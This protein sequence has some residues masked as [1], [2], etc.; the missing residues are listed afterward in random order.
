MNIKYFEERLSSH[1]GAKNYWLNK[2]LESVEYKE[3]Q[4]L[5]DHCRNHYFSYVGKVEECQH[6]ITK[7][8]G[9]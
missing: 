1:E 9:K 4:D 7:L 5:Q 8:G 3:S 6:I 2:Y